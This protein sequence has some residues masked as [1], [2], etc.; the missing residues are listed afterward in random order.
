[1]KQLKYLLG[2]LTVLS[3]ALLVGCGGGGGGS[4]SDDPDPDPTPGKVKF[5]YSGR[6]NFFPDS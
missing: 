6:S 2:L 3:L 4:S 1:M 5:I